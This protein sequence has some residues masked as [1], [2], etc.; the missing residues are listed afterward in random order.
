[1][2][3]KLL[4][5]KF[6]IEDKTTFHMS[7][8]FAVRFFN[9]FAEMGNLLERCIDQLTE[10][11]ETIKVILDEDEELVEGEDIMVTDGDAVRIAD[12]KAYPNGELYVHIRE[13][14]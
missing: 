11:M 6:K 3:T 12:I 14:F 13:K 5:P 2:T 1:M 9:S 8:E 10:A 4:Q 7:G